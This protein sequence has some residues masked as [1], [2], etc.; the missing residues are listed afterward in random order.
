MFS[1]LSLAVFLFLA[2]SSARITG[3]PC[4]LSALLPAGLRV[5]CSTINLIEL[6]HLPSDTTELHL[7][8]NQLTSVYPGLFDRLVDLKK[9][10]LSGNPFHCDCRIRYLRNWLLKNRAIVSKEPTC[11]SPS[12]VAQK[13]ISDLSD[14]YFSSCTPA[15]CTDGTYNIVVGVV[16]C[17]LIV[18]L[19]WSLRLAKISTFTLYILERHSGFEAD[20]LRSLKPKH[21]RRLDIALSDVSPD[22]D[23]L[24][25]TEDLE[26]PLIN[27]ELLPQVLD[28]LHRKHNIKIKA[29]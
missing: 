1:G 11:A 27:M 16:L 28:V 9:V 2:T 4:L 3:Q 6:P 23:S 22:S 24:T 21:R 10:S 29:T 20:S 13:A 26:K 5:N 15:S 19:L 8:D 7:Q 25:C 14:D 18:L 12:S 17:C